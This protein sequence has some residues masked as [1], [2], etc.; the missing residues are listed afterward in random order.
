MWLS[1]NTKVLD[2]SPPQKWVVYAWSM[3]SD[4]SVFGKWRSLHRRQKNYGLQTI[5]HV[6]NI[7]PVS[8]STGTYFLPKQTDF[9]QIANSVLIKVKPAIPSLFNSLEVLSSAS[10]KAKLV[11]KN[12]SKSSNLDD[13]IISLP[14]FASRTNLKLHNISIP[15]KMVRWLTRP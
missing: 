4:Y 6:H 14:M 13:S 10:D 15:P 7:A 1:R 3:W 9:W 5:A 2:S 11:A 12:F 8:C